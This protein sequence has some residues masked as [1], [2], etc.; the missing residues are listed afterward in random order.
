VFRPLTYTSL[1]LGRGSGN[2]VEARSSFSEHMA[3]NQ[4]CLQV[5]ATGISKKHWPFTAVSLFGENYGVSTPQTRQ[6][7]PAVI[8]HPNICK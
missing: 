4:R 7:P 1:P 6:W 2:T 8:N 3:C 5:Y